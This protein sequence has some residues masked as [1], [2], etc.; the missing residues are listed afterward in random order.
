MHRNVIAQC[1]W[2]GARQ[3]VIDFPE[4]WDR[5]NPPVPELEGTN[6]QQAEREGDGY[7]L[8]DGRLMTDAEPLAAP[9]PVYP[10]MA[11]LVWKE[12]ICEVRFAI[13]PTG[14]ASDVRAA[15]SDPVFIRSAEA[16]VSEVPFQPRML[17]DTP[18]PRYNVVYPLDFCM[19]K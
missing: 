3:A 4:D 12:G 10:K 18:L 13:L 16:A 8:A 14:K 6:W 5:K 15:C 17:G 11:S 7:R 1:G 2:P 9:S 19:E